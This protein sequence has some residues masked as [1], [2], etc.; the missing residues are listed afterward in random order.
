MPSF[1]LSDGS[2]RVLQACDET[3]ALITDEGENTS[4]FLGHRIELVIQKLL[5][6]ERMFHPR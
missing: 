5:D 1:S 4:V 2:S 3:L 6:Y